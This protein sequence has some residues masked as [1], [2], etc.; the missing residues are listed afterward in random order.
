MSSN[1]GIPAIDV[2]AAAERVAAETDPGALI[3][4]V[5]EPDE[6][7]AVRVERA[8]HVPMSVFVNRAAELPRDRPL[9]ILCAS[10][11][12]S[13]AVTGYLLRS[14]W[15]DVTNIEGGIKAWEGAGLPVRRGPVAAGE[16]SLPAD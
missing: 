3:V 11:V 6:F 10:G 7:I 8:A 1:P 14:G 16:G 9:L 4:D 2:R 5:R 15:T 12:R 13:S